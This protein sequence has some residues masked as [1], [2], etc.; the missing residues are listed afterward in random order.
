AV[1]AILAVRNVPESIRMSQ[2][3]VPGMPARAVGVFHMQVDGDFSEI[4][5]K[6]AV[7]RASRPGLGLRGL[8]LGRCT[9]RQQVRLPKPQRICDGLESVIQHSTRIS[10]VMALRGGELL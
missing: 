7:S 2:R 9:G 8:R 5:Q 1:K 6:G 4:V 3:S 10:M